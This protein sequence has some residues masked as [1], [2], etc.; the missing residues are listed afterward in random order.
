MVKDKSRVGISFIFPE[1]WKNCKFPLA[2]MKLLSYLN[3]SREISPAKNS[4]KGG[5]EGRLNGLISLVYNSKIIYKRKH[6]VNLI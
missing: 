3:K 4:S 6:N 2:D 5:R 1:P